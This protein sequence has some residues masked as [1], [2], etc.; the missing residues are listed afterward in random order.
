[1]CSLYRLELRMENDKVKINRSLKIVMILFFYKF[2]LDIS[3]FTFIEK[4][5]GYI[6][7]VTDFNMLKF[8]VSNVYLAIIYLIMPKK[9][10]RPSHVFLQLHL[11]IMIIP[12][13]SLYGVQNKPSLYIG[14]VVIMF[15]L[16]T[17]IIRSS[18]K[19]KLMKIKHSNKILLLLITSISLFV[20]FSMIRANGLPSLR[21][22]NFFSVYEM[23]G[24]VVYPF[25]MNYLV[26]WQAKV[27]NPLLITISYL[28]K[29]TKLLTFSMLLQ[30]VL[31]LITAHKSF[32]LIPFAIIVVIKALDKY[33]FFKVAAYLSSLGI[34]ASLILYK[35]FNLILFPFII[36]YRFLFLPAQIKY[37]YYD[38]FSNHS[39]IYFSE[40]LIGETFGLNSPYEMPTH[41]MISSIYFGLPDS[42]ANTGYL[43]DAYSNGG[44]LGM[45]IITI[46]LSFIFIIIDSLT[47][48]IRKNLVIGMS[49]FLIIGLNDLGLLT[50]LL[51]GGMI[52]LILVL[53]LEN[54]SRLLTGGNTNC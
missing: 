26:H 37:Y 15:V 50:T 29:K 13:L 47:V 9:S 43:A 22:L 30:I 4:Q 3:V 46:I 42:A 48:H 51:T 32:I 40:G 28:N 36:I 54:E 44:F 17:L 14:M 49:I 19:I 5:Y 38:F 41:N 1:M 23:R 18:K 10:E 16:Q 35:V 53:Y 21:A 24:S 11:I 52:F 7:G 6:G 2:L 8:L 39:F 27:I 33:D 34:V 31:Y 45:L 12:M 25:L 20:Y